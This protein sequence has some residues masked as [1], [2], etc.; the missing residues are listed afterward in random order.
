MLVCGRRRVTREREEAKC[1]AGEFSFL[2]VAVNTGAPRFPIEVMVVVLLLLLVESVGLRVCRVSCEGG[3]R[4][5]VHMSA[6]VSETCLQQPRPFCTLN[7]HTLSA[8]NAPTHMSSNVLTHS[9]CSPAPNHRPAVAKIGQRDDQTRAEGKPSRQTRVKNPRSDYSGQNPTHHT[10][11]RG[12][13]MQGSV[14]L[15]TVAGAVRAAGRHRRRLPAPS[16][17]T[18]RVGVWAGLSSPLPP[19]LPPSLFISHINTSR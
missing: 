5:E 2:L 3:G 10:H 7:S 9:P 14:L 15:T 6:K 11:T 18:V 19:P 12:S 4:E 13:T 8:S 1:R 17:L 16:L